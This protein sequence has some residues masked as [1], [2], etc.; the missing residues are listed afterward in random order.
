MSFKPQ[1][2]V[3]SVLLL[4]LCA[5]EEIITITADIVEDEL[6]AKQVVRYVGY[7]ASFTKIPGQ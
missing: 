4:P 1:H 5:K 7:T 6:G 2:V 3:I